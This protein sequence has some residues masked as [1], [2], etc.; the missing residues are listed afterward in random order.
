MILVSFGLNDIDVYI[1]VLDKTVIK[2]QDLP[3]PFF[4]W[5]VSPEKMNLPL[6]LKLK[7]PLTKIPWA[8]GLKTIVKIDD[9][10]RALSENWLFFLL[11][12]LTFHFLFCMLC[13]KNVIRFSCVGW[14]SLVKDKRFFFYKPQRVITQNRSNSG[15]SGCPVTTKH[16]L[17]RRAF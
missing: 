1:F 14:T 6:A 5:N 17:T 2:L 9:I 10:G 8:N 7:V 13:G 12:T 15:F 4:I 3:V 16:N 11:A